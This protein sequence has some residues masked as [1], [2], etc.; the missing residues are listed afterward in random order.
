MR[1]HIG[2]KKIA[3]FSIPV[4]S[5][6]TS[7]AKGSDAQRGHSKTGHRSPYA[8]AVHQ[9]TALMKLALL[10][11]SLPTALDIHRYISCGLVPGEVNQ[12]TGVCGGGSV[13][14]KHFSRGAGP[15][16]TSITIPDEVCK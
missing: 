13:L 8:P 4:S 1:I 9:L 11:S 3:P 7:F 5:L 10:P 14:D 6:A 2:L 12:F 15:F 16:W